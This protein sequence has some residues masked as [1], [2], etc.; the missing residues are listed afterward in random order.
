MSKR[1][2]AQQ[3]A[4]LVKPGMTVMVGGF[5]GSGAP[6]AV[7]DALVEKGTGDLTLICNDTGFIDRGSG[8]MIATKQ[9]SK[10]IVSHIGTNPETGNQMNAGQLEVS[11]VP[12]GTLAERVRCGGTGLAGVFTPTG[13]GTEVAEGKEKRSFHGKDYI[14]EE[15]LRGEIAIIKG[16]KADEKGNLI[17]RR[18]GRNFNPLMA[19]AAD[20]VIAEVGEIVETGGLD[21]DEVMTPGIL[22]DYLVLAHKTV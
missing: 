15:A 5:L 17:Y 8:K 1:I 10:V 12:Q 14:L 13:V 20:V 18:T 19:M 4:E 11:L 3:A 6:D 21:P 22:V 2:S 16:L 9:W 7:I